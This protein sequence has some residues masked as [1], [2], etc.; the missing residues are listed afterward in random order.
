MENEW[1]SR[2]RGKR[3][4][5]VWQEIFL[6][7]MYPYTWVSAMQTS[8]MK[9]SPL[10]EG[11][12]TTV[13]LFHPACLP[14]LER[15]KSAD[16]AAKRSWLLRLMIALMAGSNEC[17][18]DSFHR[19]AEL[20]AGRLCPAGSAPDAFHSSHLCTDKLIGGAGCQSGLVIHWF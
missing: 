11:I 13:R 1:D 2:A 8:L 7:C 14:A 5:H 16:R 18:L 15:W 20:P 4:E 12:V 19:S 6:N 10:M 17:R 3:E 9:S